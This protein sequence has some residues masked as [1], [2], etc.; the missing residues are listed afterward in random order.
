[1][2]CAVNA[3]GIFAFSTYRCRLAGA[4]ANANN[5][6]RFLDVTRPWRHSFS[7]MGR[8]LQSKT[9]MSTRRAAVG[10]QVQGVGTQKQQW[11]MPGLKFG[12]LEEKDVVMPS[13]L[14]TASWM[15][16]GCQHLFT[17][18]GCLDCRICQFDTT[19]ILLPEALR[20]ANQAPT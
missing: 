18:Q 20:G 7:S 1:M 11:I 2:Y 4:H 8:I 3:T 5:I 19:I 6:E 12:C 14:G 13:N 15:D 9:M 17:S 16:S 10:D